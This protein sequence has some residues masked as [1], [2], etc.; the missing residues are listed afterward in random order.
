MRSPNCAWSRRRDRSKNRCC[1]RRESAAPPAEREIFTGV[2]IVG[3]DEPPAAVR[4][5]L[6][7]S[8]I[9]GCS[10]PEMADSGCRFVSRYFPASSAISTPCSLENDRSAQTITPP[11]MSTCLVARS[12]P[13]STASTAALAVSSPAT[14]SAGQNR[15]SHSLTL[16]NTAKC[17]SRTSV[18]SLRASRVCRNWLQKSN[19]PQFLF[20]AT[21]LAE[22]CL[23]AAPFISWRKSRTVTLNSCWRPTGATVDTIFA[24]VGSTSSEVAKNPL[25]GSSSC[26]SFSSDV[27]GTARAVSGNR[28]CMVLSTCEAGQAARPRAP[29]PREESTP[30]GAPA[31]NACTPGCCSWNFFFAR[32]S[33]AVSCGGRGICCLKAC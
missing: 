2:E 3:P 19:T 11:T 14:C 24:L 30:A 25:R 32:R 20:A 26:F 1:C 33:L 29:G 4:S 7:S 13:S 28:I 22:D 15:S 31:G 9:P 16:W 23:I 6:A 8:S 10:R 18:A 17:F 27:V 21:A 5:P 12:N